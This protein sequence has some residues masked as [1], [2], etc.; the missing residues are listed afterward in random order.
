MYTERTDAAE[1]KDL[2]AALGCDAIQFRSFQ[3]LRKEL[4]QRG[5]LT[6]VD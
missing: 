1:M 2:A 5:L 6:P 4:T 3:Q